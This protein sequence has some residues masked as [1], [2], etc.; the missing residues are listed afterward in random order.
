M[1]RLWSKVQSRLLTRAFYDAKRSCMKSE[2]RI[3]FMNNKIKSCILL[4]GMPVVVYLVFRLL[5]PERFGSFDSI[6]IL[7][8]QSLIY[9]ITGC[10]CYFIIAMGVFDFSVGAMI[11]MSCLV[12]CQLS[13]R[14]GYVGLI[15]GCII[16]GTLHRLTRAH[17][18]L[19]CAMDK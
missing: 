5:A 2:G 11:I 10:G 16:V 18:P 13:A 15:A 8:Q 9:A 14:F 4:L 6:Y 12:G 1:I 3:L 7:L 19:S 17:S